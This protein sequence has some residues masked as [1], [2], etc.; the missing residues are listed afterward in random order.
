MISRSRI[1]IFCAG[2]S[3]AA[4]VLLLL[5]LA[6][7]SYK[8]FSTSILYNSNRFSGADLGGRS[9][10]VS[11]LF[12]P[13]GVVVDGELTSRIEIETI[14]KKRRTLPLVP[15]ELFEEQYTAT[16]GKDAL[17][18]FYTGLYKGEMVALQS[19]E[20][21]WKQIGSDYLMV[22]KLT[23]GLRVMSGKEKSARRLRLE[24]ELWDCDSIEVLWRVAVDS[25]IMGERH[26]DRQVLLDAICRVFE[27]L[28]PV[29]PGYGKGRW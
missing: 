27:A 4:T 15:H 12:T 16:S 22:L 29:I 1:R 7:G 8:Q 10:T 9:I 23:Y 20:K 25:R 6:C 14:N 3:I 11:P 19:M 5:C 18:S 17:D 21:P 28:P 26:T 13:R 2:G 24:G